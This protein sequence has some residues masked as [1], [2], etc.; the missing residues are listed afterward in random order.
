MFPR[1]APTEAMSPLIHSDFHPQST[2]TMALL[3]TYA[4]DI[5]SA[6][7]TMSPYCTAETLPSKSFHPQAP[8]V[9]VAPT[10]PLAVEDARQKLIASAARIQQLA[11]EP[12]E[13]LPNLAIYVRLTPSFSVSVRKRS[14][15]TV[16]ISIPASHVALFGHVGF[17]RICMS[18][19]ILVPV[20]STC[21]RPLALPLR[22]PRL[23]SSP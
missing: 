2:G 3:E 22:Y 14:N 19:L 10:A 17:A 12:A 7:E 20:P 18:S 9:T 21:M 15:F 8:S 1:A 11:T 13:Y 4:K 16:M 5:C 6:V 23:H